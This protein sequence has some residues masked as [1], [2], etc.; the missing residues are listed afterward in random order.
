MMEVITTLPPPPNDLP[1]PEP[2]TAPQQP[3]QQPQHPE[4]RPEIINEVL[5]SKPGILG[6]LIN[7]PVSLV[8]Q[9]SGLFNAY[10]VVSITSTV[11][12]KPGKWLGPVVVDECC[13]TKGWSVSMVHDDFLKQ[14][15]G[16]MIQLPKLALP[17][18]L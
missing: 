2:Q 15:L 14:L 12:Y 7:K 18:G 6:G 3:H 10:Q 16:S 11:I 9:Y 13:T 17:G 8:L 4:G 5:H 1:K